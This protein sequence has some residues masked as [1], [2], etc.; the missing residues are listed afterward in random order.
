MLGTAVQE[1]G[2]SAREYM[3]TMPRTHRGARAGAHPGR[4]GQPACLC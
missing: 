4:R 2:A 1:G 3:A